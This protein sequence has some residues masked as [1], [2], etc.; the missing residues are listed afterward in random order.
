[1]SYSRWGASDWYI[2]YS[3]SSGDTLSSQRLAIWHLG[4]DDLPEYTYSQLKEDR[5]SVWRDVTSHVYEI[6][7][8]ETFDRCVDSFLLDAESKEFLPG[9]K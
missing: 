4:D 3:S 1:M 7:D 2:Y 5:E 6:S 9:D 8:R